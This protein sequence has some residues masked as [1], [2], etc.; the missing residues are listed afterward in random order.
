MRVNGEMASCQGCDS[1]HAIDAL[2]CKMLCQNC[3]AKR[4]M[5]PVE[6]SR[7]IARGE[8]YV[9]DIQALRD[10]FGCKA[11]AT[12]SA[13]EEQDETDTVVYACAD[14]LGHLLGD[15]YWFVRP[16]EPVE[17]T[18]SISQTHGVIREGF[19]SPMILAPL[20]ITAPVVDLGTN[21]TREQI[22]AAGFSG[23]GA[24]YREALAAFVSMPPPTPQTVGVLRAPRATA[25]RNE[26]G[27]I[28]DR[29]FCET[30]ERIGS[31]LVTAWR[32]HGCKQDAFSYT[33]ASATIQPSTCC[34]TRAEQIRLA[35][36]GT[37][38]EA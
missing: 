24:A 37:F 23:D 18:I 19:G 10:R 15:R 11:E 27:V 13:I 3:R 9:Y 20:P 6:V 8:P 7:A 2:D 26:A 4:G 36:A 16:Y 35:D 38:T 32:C 21:P 29:A 33:L 25:T 1:R 17:V 14:H 30:F 28:I 34:G 5:P 22:E 12:H 31:Y